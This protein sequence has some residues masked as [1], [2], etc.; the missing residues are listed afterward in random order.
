MSALP[1]FWV[2]LLGAATEPPAALLMLRDPHE[3]A[4]SQMARSVQNPEAYPGLT[5]PEAMLAIWV[6]QTRACL[7]QL[8]DRPI[9]VVRH[10]DLAADAR[11]RFARILV[12]A[13]HGDGGIERI[14]GL[15]KPHYYRSRPLG[16]RMNGTWS[17]LAER[18]F[19]AL[20]AAA[21]AKSNA[22]NQRA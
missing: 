8:A 19:G 10:A 16:G 18:L 9:L 13:G 3:V 17:P 2:P 1:G 20:G 12:F 5:G 22:P 15:F 21:A 14:E 4:A 6:R 7:R 11:A